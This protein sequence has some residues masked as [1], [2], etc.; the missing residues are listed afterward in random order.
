MNKSCSVSNILSGDLIFYPWDEII[1]TSDLRKNIIRQWSNNNIKNFEDEKEIF[2]YVFEK[3]LNF[4]E[5]IF[6]YFLW[7]QLFKNKEIKII[8]KEIIN[9]E[10]NY[11]E[12]NLADLSPYEEFRIPLYFLIDCREKTGWITQNLNSSN[13][14]FS[15]LIVW[16]NNQHILRNYYKN[17]I[18][19]KV[20]FILN[21][22]FIFE[23]QKKQKINYF[24]LT[25]EELKNIL[26]KYNQQIYQIE[27]DKLVLLPPYWLTT[28]CIYPSYYNNGKFRE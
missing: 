6:K 21:N 7:I 2:S 5:Q 25:I 13:I 12:L 23:E 20:T 8:Q 28:E 9:L 10:N 26:K 14:Y 27:K 3:N 22:I 17:I 19:D 18:E 1:L 15:P 4:Y 11:Y 16:E 24:D